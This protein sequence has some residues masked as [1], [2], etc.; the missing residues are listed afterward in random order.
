MLICCAWCESV[1]TNG[2]LWFRPT[3][4]RF[5]LRTRERETGVS[6]GICPGCF[7]ALAPDVAYPVPTSRAAA[8]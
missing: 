3:P 4:W 5:A 1:S 7:A 2:E 8:G 6:H